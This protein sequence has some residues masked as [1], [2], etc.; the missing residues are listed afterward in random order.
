MNM[1]QFSN[2]CIEY[3][4]EFKSDV[5]MRDPIRYFLSN[6]TKLL[7]FCRCFFSLIF[8]SSK[9]LTNVITESLEL[10]GIFEKRS[11]KA[12]ISECAGELEHEIE[13]LEW[14]NPNDYRSVQN[15]TFYVKKEIGGNELNK[16][17]R[18]VILLMIFSQSIIREFGKDSVNLYF[19]KNKHKLE[20]ELQDLY[21]TTHAQILI[22]L[23]LNQF[24]LK[25]IRNDF[26][27]LSREKRE[28]SINNNLEITKEAKRV[29]SRMKDFGLQMINDNKLDKTKKYDIYASLTFIGDR[30]MKALCNLSDFKT[31][32]EFPNISLILNA[33]VCDSLKDNQRLREFCNMDKLFLERRQARL[34]T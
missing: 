6:D 28:T 27:K 14:Y 9:H 18:I 16:Q 21:F 11:I 20:E 32:A 33:A 34:L 23:S 31:A 29:S 24:N 22:V 7:L 8:R 30:Y 12:L 26:R 3:M 2:E 19:D 13:S 4:S 10:L 5:G 15:E 25:E 1:E 17:I